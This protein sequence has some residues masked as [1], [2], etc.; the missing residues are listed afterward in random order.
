MSLRLN[1][2]IFCLIPLLL[3]GCNTNKN[4]SKS[5]QSSTPT[6][7]SSLDD[8]F[9][10][11]VHD[12]IAATFSSG[13]YSK[14]IRIATPV[15]N[16]GKIN[17]CLYSCEYTI[18]NQY[19]EKFQNISAY[20]LYCA[21]N[22]IKPGETGY[23]YTGCTF[24]Q[25]ENMDDYVVNQIVTI[26]KAPN[27]TCHRY[28]ASEITIDT[29]TDFLHRPI[30]KGSFTNDT[31]ERRKDLRYAVHVFDKSGIYVESHVSSF[32]EGFNP[33]E[34]K[35][36]TLYYEDYFNCLAFEDVG[37]FEVVAYSYETI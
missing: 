17:I 31:S 24:Y 19:G 20:S 11:E 29:E 23:F 21:P 12:P 13:I 36:Y 14:N 34:S 10:Y 3:C 6:S 18:S 32:S 27:T 28:P 7:S 33:G 1:K 25:G 22:I 4:S 35:E 2:L 37:H 8:G 30:L 9:D 5:G 26:K 16:T 15:K